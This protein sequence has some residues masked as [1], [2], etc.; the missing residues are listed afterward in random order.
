MHV[1]VSAARRVAQ[2]MWDQRR[3]LVTCQMGINRSGLISALALYFASGGRI[4]GRQA[5]NLVKSGRPGAL[6]NLSFLALLDSL[7]V[8]RNPVRAFPL[9]GLPM[10]RRRAR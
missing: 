4:S 9:D 3:V 6:S 1:A 2:A 5:A 10:R 8:E 7:P